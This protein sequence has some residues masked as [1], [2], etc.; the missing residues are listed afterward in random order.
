MATATLVTHLEDFNGRASLYR[1]SEPVHYTSYDE[2]C[3]EVH[4]STEYVVVSAVVAPFSGP[5]TYIFPANSTGEVVNWCELPGSFR[6]DLDHDRAL[7]NAGYSV[8]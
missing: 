2:S 8:E 1:L 6:G 4:H 7:S 3:N 5:E